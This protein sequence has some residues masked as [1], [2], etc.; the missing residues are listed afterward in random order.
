M[1]SFFTLINDL[2]IFFGTSTA[3]L[4]ALSTGS[5]VKSIENSFHPKEWVRPN[6]FVFVHLEMMFLFCIHF[7]V[8]VFGFKLSL[9]IRSMLLGICIFLVFL[10]VRPLCF[11]VLFA[12]SGGVSVGLFLLF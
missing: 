3:F 5:C 1:R 8:L 6:S 2:V 9:V 10:R 4:L 7:L 12:L 11:V